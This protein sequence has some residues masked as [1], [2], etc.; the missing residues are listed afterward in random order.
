MI[1]DDGPMCWN[2]EKM[3]ARER[4]VEFHVAVGGDIARKGGG[5]YLTKH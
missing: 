1:G 3:E 5:C 2:W 4:K